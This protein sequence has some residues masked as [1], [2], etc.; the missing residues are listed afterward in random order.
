MNDESLRSVTRTP[1]SR[2]VTLFLLKS[3]KMNNYYKGKAGTTE[4]SMF[5][6]NMNYP[7]LRLKSNY[8]Y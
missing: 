5:G 3:L 6:N 7:E 4:Q 2:N 1:L 8:R